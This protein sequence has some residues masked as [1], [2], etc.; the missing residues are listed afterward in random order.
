MEYSA[1]K[2]LCCLIV[3]FWAAVIFAAD[4]TPPNI[5]PNVPVQWKCTTASHPWIDKPDLTLASRDAQPSGRIITVYPDR[6]FQQIDGWGGCFNERGWRAMQILSPDERD[7]VMRAMFDPADGMKLNICRTPLGESDYSISLYSYD[8]T[9][10][11]FQMEHFSIAHDR[12]LLI[13]YIKAA[14]ALQPKLKVWAVP[15]SPPI[16]MKNIGNLAGGHIKTDGRTQDALALYFARYVQAYRGEGIPLFMVMPQNEPTNTRGRTA[17]G[18][19]GAEMGLFVRDHLGPLFKKLDLNCQIYLGTF[20]RS[21]PGFDYNFWLASSLSD[22]VT[23]SY[24]TGVGC[25][26]GGDPVMR[27]AHARYP[28]LKLMQTEADCGKTNTNDW[29]FASTVY[30][31]MTTYFRS[32][33]ESYMIWNLL[34]DETGLN[35]ETWAQCSPIVVNQKTKEVV[36]TPYFY[37]YKHFSNFVE[38]GAFRVDVVA[39]GKSPKCTA[40]LNPNGQLVLVAENAMDKDAPVTLN[41]GGK[42]FAA[43]LPAKSFNTFTLDMKSSRI[44]RH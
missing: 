6:R 41:L 3:S 11:D 36:Y 19:T 22:P 1:K 44:S 33:A 8:D 5:I 14:L 32:G 40:F 43:T 16:W 15:W 10:D 34:L 18:W 25:Q 20:N 26:Y 28:E 37:M 23:R 2:L 29:N 12:A 30:G 9:P 17:C 39:S 13:P 31:R 38:P 4:Q 27:E 35:Y 24:V 21:S 7:R 42:F